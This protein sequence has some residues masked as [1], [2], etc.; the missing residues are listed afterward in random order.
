MGD[1]VAFGDDAAAA[2]GLG[3]WP[4]G[5]DGTPIFCGDA[6]ADPLT[7]MHAA[8]AALS[9]WQR[10]DG[11]LLD[12]A[13]QRVATFVAAQ[14]VALPRGHVRACAL[15]DGVRGWEVVVSEERWV[16]AAP[17]ARP[18]TARA[19]DIGADTHDVLRELGISC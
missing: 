18:A 7:A 1:W 10:G 2:G 19:S 15:V 11:A 4:E 13:L 8:L 17:R 16:V 6:V 12:V 3:V 5:T 9:H 14:P